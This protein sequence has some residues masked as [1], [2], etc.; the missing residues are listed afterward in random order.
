MKGSRIYRAKSV[1]NVELNQV[2]QGRGGGVAHV[3]VDVGKRAILAVLRWGEGFERPWLVKNPEEVREFVGL[4]TELK[5][6]RELRVAM[7][8]TGTYGEVLRQ[9]LSDAGIRVERVNPKVAHDYAEVFDGVPSQFDG[10]DAAVVAELLALGKSQEWKYEAPSE[11]EQE[12]AYWVDW[13]DA[14]RRQG[15]MWLGRLEALLAR[16]WPEATR[17]LK[18]SSATLLRI[19]QHYGGPKGLAND[20]RALARMATWGGH[21][22]A[23]EKIRAVLGDARQTVGVRQGPVDMRRMQVCA[24]Q[25]LAARKE[26]ARSKRQ[27]TT[28]ARGN[29]VIQAQ[30]RAVGVATACV[31][32]VHLGDPRCYCCAAAYRKAMGLNLREYSSGQYQGRLRIS[33]RG[34]APVRRWLYFAALRWIRCGPARRWYLRKRA[35]DGDEAQRAVIGVMRKLAKGLHRVGTTGESF[36]PEQLFAGRSCRGRKAAKRLLAGRR[37]DR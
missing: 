34:A 25:A 1:K 12:M 21:H 29:G 9:A 16:Y 6:G 19:V 35:R 20:E 33:K 10:K 13:M 17:R 37:S 5:R 28:L 18:L 23:L 3:G 27:L 8:P 36:R 2:V 32:W 15:M 11:A 4:L 30:A 31:L 14:Q 24:G 22:L 7:E 26:V